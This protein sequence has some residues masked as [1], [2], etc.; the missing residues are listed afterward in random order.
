MHTNKYRSVYYGK[1]ARRIYSYTRSE[2][3][4][5]VSCRRKSRFLKMKTHKCVVAIELKWNRV[6]LSDA[7][8]RPKI[9]RRANENE[10]YIIRRYLTRLTIS[11]RDVPVWLNRLIFCRLRVCTTGVRTT[12]QSQVVFQRHTQ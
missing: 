6:V 10:W 11:H 5:V 1:S 3:R 12:L 9:K 7:S 4:T 8:R 2:H